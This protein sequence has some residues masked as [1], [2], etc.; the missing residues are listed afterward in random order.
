M[1]QEPTKKIYREEALQSFYAGENAPGQVVRLSPASLDHAYW[2]LAVAFLV[3]GV[4]LI[5]GRL[6]QYATGPAVVRAQ[7]LIPVSSSQQGVVV[8]V[9]VSPGDAV[10]RGQALVRL[11]AGAPQAEHERLEREY[12][13]QL[14]KTLRDPENAVAR[15]A[16]ATLTGQRE[17]ARAH[18]EERTLRA[19]TSGSISDVRVRPGQNLAPGEVAVTVAG[20]NTHFTV[21]ALLPGHQRPFLRP[22]SPLR[23][24]LAGFRYNHQSLVTSQ[25]GNVILGPAEVRRVLGPEMADAV[26]FSGPQV[27]VTAEVDDTTFMA[28]GLRL[29]FYDGMMGRADIP[30]RRERIILVMFPW[31]RGLRS[32]DG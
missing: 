10:Q 27:R 22:G 12:Q 3:V 23:F 28:D 17:A 16:L 5:F 21:V 26:E 32:N 19:P 7:G 2:L 25:V 15:E 6:N 31:L 24:E 8:A 18:L 14:M 20:E 4:V 1:T 11:H 9:L 13:V 29:R 30:V